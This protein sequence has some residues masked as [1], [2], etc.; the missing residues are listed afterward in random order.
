MYHVKWEFLTLLLLLLHFLFSRCVPFLPLS[1]SL[2][3]GSEF[4][5]V[6]LY[7]GYNHNHSDLGT[8]SY[9]NHNFSTINVQLFGQTEQRDLEGLAEKGCRCTL[10]K[11]GE[12]ISEWKRTHEWDARKGNSV[13]IH[14]RSMSFSQ[15]LFQSCLVVIQVSISSYTSSSCV[16]AQESVV[17]VVD[18]FKQSIRSSATLQK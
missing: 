17:I 15:E 2:T 3:R 14:T 4:S 12:W 10:E 6:P 9:H 11:E 16:L 7:N 13:E 1:L 18:T 5:F 8:D